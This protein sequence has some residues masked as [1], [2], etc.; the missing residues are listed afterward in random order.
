MSG[1][2]ERPEKVMRMRAHSDTTVDSTG[3]K[4]LGRALSRSVRVKKPL[5][6]SR[7]PAS[8][9]QK[10]VVQKVRGVKD[11]VASHWEWQNSR[12]T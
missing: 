7:G 8:M 1:I 11:R 12:A 4:T 5:H 10:T 3:R 6:M 2:R 9:L